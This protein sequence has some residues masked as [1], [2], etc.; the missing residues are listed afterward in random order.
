M[1]FQNPASR[2]LSRHTRISSILGV[3]ALNHMLG[4]SEPIAKS[5]RGKMWT[6]RMIH[7]QGRE[8][9]YRISTGSWGHR[10]WSYSSRQCWCSCC[11]VVGRRRCR[12]WSGAESRA[13]RTPRWTLSGTRGRRD[14]PDPDHPAGRRTWTSAGE[15]ASS[16]APAHS[17]AE[18]CAPL[19]NITPAVDGTQ[20]IN[21]PWMSP[22]ALLH[23]CNGPAVWK[24]IE[25]SLQCSQPAA[26]LPRGSHLAP[27]L[28]F[29]TGRGKSWALP[30]EK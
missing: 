29:W 22:H 23:K 20:I 26:S 1:V 7:T 30:S 28:G 15:P 11:L 21:F 2:I 5:V 27:F 3:T 13:E 12:P 4:S 25:V 10:S 19:L 8:G 17:R 16:L 9:M 24:W 6:C 14:P 18:S